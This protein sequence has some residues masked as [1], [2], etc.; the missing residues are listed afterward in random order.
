ME[1]V[2]FKD[3]SNINLLNNKYYALKFDLETEDD[4][5]LNNKIYKNQEL[6]TH[7]QPKHELAKF[8]TGKQDKIPIPAIIILD[9]D[10]KVVEQLHTYLSPKQLYL[11][12]NQ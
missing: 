6:K 5:I 1:K 12:I 2:S 9:Q 3:K 8:L 4:I 10:F 7:R 11:L